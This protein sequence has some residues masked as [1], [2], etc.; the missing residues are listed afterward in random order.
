VNGISQGASTPQFQPITLSNNDIISC[1]LTSSANCL[2]NSTSISNTSAITVNP[3]PIFVTSSNSPICSGN[4][5]NLSSTSLAGSTYSWTGPNGFSS[6][7]QNPSL[8]S[9]TV[10]MSG[11]YSLMVTSN[12]CSTTNA[13]TVV[14]NA[15]PP[16]PIISSNGMTLTSSS[17]N[18]NQ[19]VYNGVNIAGANSTTY[20]ATQN[21]TYTVVITQDGCTATSAPFN[22]TSAGIEENNSVTNGI[23]IFPN[24][25]TGLFTLKFNQKEIANYSIEVR[26]LN[27]Q[28]VDSYE[29]NNVT[30]EFNYSMDLQSQSKGMYF[31]HVNNGSKTVIQKISIQ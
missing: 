6:S 8:T 5:V 11:S 20:V 19:W 31:I 28:L 7:S 17:P 18:G 3:S 4:T 13:L 16:T 14:V 10:A 30:N 25:S 21:G 27:G 15:T 24:P 12:G 26:S 1:V 9:S 2:T 23:V 29:L 22:E